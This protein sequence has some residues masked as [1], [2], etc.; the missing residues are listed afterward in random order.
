MRLDELDVAIAGAGVGGLA[1]G[2]LLARFGARVTLYDQME[3]PRPIGSGFVLQPT[4][5]QVLASMGLLDPVAARGRRI[6]RMVGRLKDGGKPVLDVGYRSGEFGTAVQRV[7][8]FDVLFEAARAAG[9]TFEPSRRIAGIEDGARPCLVDAFGRR[10]AP[11]DF[12]I[13]AMGANSPI[14]NR[15]DSELSYGA[16]WAT[17]PFP[18]SGAFRENLLEQRYARASRMAGVL[19]VGTAH[20]GAPAMATFF[21]SLRTADYAAWQTA[22]RDAWLEAVGRLWPDAVPLAAVADPVH[23]RYRHLTRQPVIGRNT[24]KIGDAWHATSPQLGQGANMA[25]LDAASLASAF[26]HAEDA[27]AAISRHLQQRQMHVRSYQLLSQVLTPFYQSDSRLLP[28]LR[29]HLI[30]PVT[31]LPGIRSVISTL[32]TGDLLDPVGRLRLPE[33]FGPGAVAPSQP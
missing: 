13:D 1:L 31:T 21:W 11:A 16:L 32:V 25:L 19:P 5:A 30:A 4:G 24:L 33:T 23:A 14:G 3:A 9:V 7:A 12:V 26:I 17:V 29:D 18:S 22:G 2:T 6:D 8:L 28:V 15:P 10:S 27:G 20:E